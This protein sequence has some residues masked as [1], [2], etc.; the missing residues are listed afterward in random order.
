MDAAAFRTCLAGQP[1]VNEVTANIPRKDVTHSQRI[2][3]NRSRYH[4]VKIRY[5]TSWRN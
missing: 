3:R 5:T 4:D 2:I 1:P